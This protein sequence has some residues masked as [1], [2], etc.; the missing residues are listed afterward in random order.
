MTFIS[1]SSILKEVIRLY[2]G[3]L[4]KGIYLYKVLSED[5]NILWNLSQ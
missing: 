4:K 5:L 2:Y 3:R 1:L